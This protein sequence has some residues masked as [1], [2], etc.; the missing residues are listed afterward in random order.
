MA[1]TWVAR[2]IASARGPVIVWPTVKAGPAANST[3]NPSGVSRRRADPIRPRSPVVA[4][5]AKLC[6][7]PL[8]I[9][10]TVARRASR[11][12]TVEIELPST[13]LT[14]LAR[15]FSKLSSWWRTTRRTVH[16]DSTLAVTSTARKARDKP[17]IRRRWRWRVDAGRSLSW[18]AARLSMVILP[19]YRV[20]VGDTC[21]GVHRHARRIP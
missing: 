20:S 21:R 12:C 18:L 13:R 3:T 15:S 9:R 17:R 14:S 4:A 19:P 5:S 8:L 6:G 10:A 2:R 1:G 7:D 16:A 11:D